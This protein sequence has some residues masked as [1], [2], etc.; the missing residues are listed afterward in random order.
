MG[1]YHCIHYMKARTY[2]GPWQHTVHDSN[3]VILL[4]CCEAPRN[5]EI[6]VSQNKP[7]SCD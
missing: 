7:H 2:V 4:Q 5:L 6:S 1:F 3:S